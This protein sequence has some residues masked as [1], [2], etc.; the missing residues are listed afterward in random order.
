M[1]HARLEAEEVMFGALDELFR[2]TNVSPTEIEILEILIVNCSVFNPT[3]SHSA[4]VVNRYKMK[5]T[6]RS[7]NLGGMGCKRG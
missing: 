4:M 5:R 6:T 2:K 1:K 7:Y 3:P